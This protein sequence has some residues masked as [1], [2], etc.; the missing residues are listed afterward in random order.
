M[1]GPLIPLWL[2]VF[3]TLFVSILLPIYCVHYGPANFLWFSDIALITLI[4]ALWLEDSLLVSMMALAVT[5][6]EIAWTIDF[7]GHLLTGHPVLGLSRYMFDA[8]RPLYLRL[9]SLFHI[10]LPIV[11]LYLL[12]R[13]GYDSR[14]LFLQTLLAWVILPLTYVLTTPS[15][16]IN[17]VHGPSTPPQRLLPPLV[18][19]GVL[20]LFFPLCL[21]LPAHFAFIKLFRVH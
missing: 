2:K 6:P 5:L 16:N 8:S 18:Y 14:A 13:L 10:P 1:A 7:L 12:S 19:L 17:W 4:P 3:H 20:M 15:Q 21:Y 11:L 9:L